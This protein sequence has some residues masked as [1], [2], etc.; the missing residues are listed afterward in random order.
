MSFLR[1]MQDMMTKRGGARWLSIYEVSSH[2]DR[3][4]PRTVAFQLS[5]SP[6]HTTTY[7]STQSPFIQ[8]SLKFSEK[9]SG[10]FVKKNAL[11][12][13]TSSCISLRRTTTSQ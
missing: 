12:R 3:A 6:L 7:V 13:A 8:A 9:I 1:D 4:I 5:R 2:L 10:L 11:R